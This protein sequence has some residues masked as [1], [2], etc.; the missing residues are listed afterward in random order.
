MVLAAA[1]AGFEGIEAEDAMFSGLVNG[2]SGGGGIS[3]DVTIVLPDETSSSFVS[4]LSDAG[5]ETNRAVGRGPEADGPLDFFRI[6]CGGGGLDDE[7][8]G[9]LTSP[10]E[11][12]E[13]CPWPGLAG[14]TGSELRV[15]GPGGA[16][17]GV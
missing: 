16:G 13:S 7:G 15:S 6:G 17:L 4:S 11:E 2:G 1:G 9:D 8:V 5:G 10:F 3:K 12:S 14:N